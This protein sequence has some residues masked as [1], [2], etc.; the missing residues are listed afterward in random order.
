MCAAFL[1]FWARNHKQRYL[2][3]RLITYCAE[4]IVVEECTVGTLPDIFL[5]VAVVD[6]LCNWISG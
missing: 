6:H 1:L 2:W 5:E 4:P 3:N